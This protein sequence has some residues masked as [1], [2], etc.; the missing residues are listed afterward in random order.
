MKYILLVSLLLSS[1]MVSANPGTDSLHYDLVNCVKGTTLAGL[2]SKIFD[3]KTEEKTDHAMSI[4]S[5]NCSIEIYLLEKEG[6][7]ESDITESLS[8]G[9]TEAINEYTPSNL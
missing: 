3:F 2:E 7:N 4:I 1:F 9:I 5:S 8:M 6:V